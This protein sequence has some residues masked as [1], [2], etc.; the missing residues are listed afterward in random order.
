MKHFTP[1]YKFSSDDIMTSP[2]S[3]MSEND[4]IIRSLQQNDITNTNALN[5]VINSSERQFKEKLKVDRQLA[6]EQ[7][8]AIKGVIDSNQNL[9]NSLEGGFDNLHIALGNI[10][11]QLE[12]QYSAMIE[13]YR[14]SN[15]RMEIIAEY[16]K[17]PEFE[18]ERLFL[19]TKAMEFLKQT[20]ISSERYYDAI[21][22]LLKANDDKD[23]FVL[24]Q[25]GLIYLYGEDLID[26]KKAIHY[27]EKAYSYANSSGNIMEKA[28]IAKHNSYCYLLRGQFKK[29][30]QWANIGLEDNYDLGL[31]FIKSEALMMTNKLKDGINILR[32]ISKKDIGYIIEAEDKECF[33]CEEFEALKKEFKN[34]A[35]KKANNIKIGI[36]KN[37][38]LTNKHKNQLNE[39]EEKL[40]FYNNSLFEVIEIHADFE[41]LYEDAKIHT[42]HNVK[43]KIDNNSSVLTSIE[44]NNLMDTLSVN[45]TL[46]EQKLNRYL[47]EHEL[48]DE[49]FKKI[50]E[51]EESKFNLN[52]ENIIFILLGIGAFIVGI[53]I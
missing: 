3:D 34:I 7:L 30:I 21:E 17:L 19:I 18:K 25:I 24:K 6:G 48:Y 49:E 10:T 36:H 11:S 37:F 27:L 13:Q 4:Q 33:K 40:S 53:L 28:S 42:Y 50:D 32:K 14:I 35:I 39:L 8:D 5:D 29:S 47:K 45:Y 12:I 22:Y 38:K 44:Y 52:I 16:I 20:F 15:S 2:Y 51:Y 31:M 43:N 9:K 26:F 1:N 41:D 46:A 23:F